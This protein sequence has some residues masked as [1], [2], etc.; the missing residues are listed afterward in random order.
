ML[1]GDVS[2]GRRDTRVHPELAIQ[3]LLP[4]A[5]QT[6]GHQEISTCSARPRRRNSLST[7]SA[8]MVLP[9][10][11]SSAKMARPLIRRSADAAARSW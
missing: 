3:L 4:L 1:A 11:T 7:R 2:G 8:S 5:D 9:R 6:R 10:P